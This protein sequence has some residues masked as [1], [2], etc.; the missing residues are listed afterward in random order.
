[1]EFLSLSEEQWKPSDLCFGKII[2][3]TERR[4]D[5]MWARVDISG[6]FRRLMKWSGMMV[7]WSMMMVVERK[8]E[9]IHS[10][11]FRSSHSSP[12]RQLN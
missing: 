2:Q 11:G 5:W 3:A 4:T 9:R 7:I 1:M 10:H 12:T 6:P 8:L